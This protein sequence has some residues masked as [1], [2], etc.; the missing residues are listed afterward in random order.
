[1]LHRGRGSSVDTQ[2]QAEADG[3]CLNLT[4]DDGWLASHPLTKA[5]LKQESSW[6]K[7]IGIKLSFA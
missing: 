1:L 7:S 2:V 3:Q 4:F 5:D 6:L